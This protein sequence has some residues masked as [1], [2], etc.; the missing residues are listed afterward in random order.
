MNPYEHV[1]RLVD[2]SPEGPEIGAL[3]DFDGTLIAGFSVTS[4]FR[5]QLL[6]GELSPTQ[7]LE[8]AAAAANFSFGNLG[9]SGLMIASAK[10][11]KGIPER[12]Y[13]EFGEQVF[14]KHVAKTIYPEARALVKAHKRRGHTV[15]IISSATPYQVNP[16]AEDF[17]I[18]HVLCSHLE[19]ED[20]VF[21]GEIV[22]PT[23][24]GH[25]KVLAAEQLARSERIDLGKSFFYS[26]S[27]E[28]LA[29]LE[30]VGVPQPLNPNPKLV[31][32]AE[33]KGWPIRRFSSRGRPRI[34]DLAR[35]VAA[36]A[37]IVPAFAAGIPISALTGSW[38]DGQNFS[39]S[40]FADVASALIGL[41][42]DVQGEHNLWVKRPAVFVFNHQSKADVVIMARLLRRDIAGV[43]K[44]E[45]A[46]VPILGQIMQLAGTVLIDRGNS[47]KAIESMKQL[48]D[49]IRVEHKSVA[50]APEGTRTATPALGHF[51]KGAFHLA[52]QAGVPIVPVVIRNASDVAPKG[53]F[54]YRPATVAVEVLEPVDTS[55]WEARTIESHVEEVR[56]L[57]L[58]TLGQL[59]APVEAENRVIEHGPPR[60][61]PARKKKA[62]GER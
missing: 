46:K 56:N 20:G 11:L 51:K 32:I 37:S 2:E 9:F 57:F 5:E 50:I 44:K 41:N 48:V 59:E 35:S 13:I 60:R 34:S 61:K 47:A 45:I 55:N 6:R 4:F 15:A 18:R 3:F 33:K 29:L 42:L 62:G 23:C 12:S 25:G 17:G 54:V 14:M 10:L 31:E 16:A 36:T 39:M 7:F 52:M 40:L 58:L 19:V 28:D 49:T 43:G 27:H 24:Y 30:R 1:T 38:R 21:T 53:E 22:R 26:D 8:V